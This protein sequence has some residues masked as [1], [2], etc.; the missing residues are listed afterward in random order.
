MRPGASGWYD[1]GQEIRPWPGA[2]LALL[3][4][5]ACTDP[6]IAEAADSP[7][8]PC[9]VC[10]L[11][12]TTMAAVPEE[13][14]TIAAEAIANGVVLRVTAAE[15]QAQ[16]ALWTACNQRQSLL[17]L[18]QRG[19]VVSLCPACRANVAAFDELRIDLLRLP[20]G[21][22]LLYTSA[23]AEIVQRLHAMVTG[24]NVPL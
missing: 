13:A 24:A 11:W 23:D 5:I 4:G 17:A 21:V 2:F 1:R 16:A 8:T 19:E 14:V 7:E 22:L 12:E 18:V 9:A 20:D 6:R 10:R 3:V 15:P